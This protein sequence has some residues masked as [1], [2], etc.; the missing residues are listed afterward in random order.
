[1][2]FSLQGNIGL[3]KAIEYFTSNQIPV[4][5][6][7]NDTQSYDIIV[8]FNGK[9]QRVQVKTTCYSKQD[10]KYYSVGLKNSGGNRT[11]KA[12]YVP[13]DNNSCD[14]LFVYTADNKCYLIP[15]DIIKVKTEL[16]IDERFIEYEVN[17]KTLCDFIES[18]PT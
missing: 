7:L 14:Y 6:P 11:G 13:F 8:D 2:Y 1:M 9:L 17:S 5:I 16:T 3:G 18:M 4:A 10:S 15:S 12:R